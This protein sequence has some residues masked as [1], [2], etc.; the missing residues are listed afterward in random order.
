MQGI[1]VKLQE[2]FYETR[3]TR[4]IIV[5]YTGFLFM[6]FAFVFYYLSW[7]YV[8]SYGIF[9]NAKAVRAAPIYTI[10]S[11]IF[12]IIGVSLITIGI[13]D[14]LVFSEKLKKI[15]RFHLNETLIQNSKTMVYERP[16]YIPPQYPPVQYYQQSQALQYQYPQQQTQTQITPLP[17]QPTPKPTVKK[18]KVKTTSDGRP[19]YKKKKIKVDEDEVAFEI[20]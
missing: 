3:L 14:Y 16:P 15:R 20:E 19:I 18:K 4:S 5:F 13:I 1:D 17:T 6:F 7:T 12:I 8:I 11:F 9:L 2:M 10:L